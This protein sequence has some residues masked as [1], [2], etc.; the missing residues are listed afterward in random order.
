MCSYLVEAHLSYN[1]KC[2]NE[3]G[4]QKVYLTLAQIGS[5]TLSHSCLKLVI[6]IHSV[7]IFK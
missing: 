3:C 7:S 6:Y 2:G 1:V 4:G 5:Q